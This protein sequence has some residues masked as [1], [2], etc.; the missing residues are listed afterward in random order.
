MKLV[1]ERFVGISPLSLS[2]VALEL[3]NNHLWLEFTSFN[4]SN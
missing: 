1:L 2:P 4:V 3:L